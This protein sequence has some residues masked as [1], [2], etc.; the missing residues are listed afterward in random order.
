MI[1]RSFILAFALVSFGSTPLSANPTRAD[2]RHL[3]DSLPE[4]VPSIEDFHEFRS[5]LDLDDDWEDLEEEYGERKAR[6]SQLEG[7]PTSPLPIGKRFTIH[8]EMIEIINDQIT[9]LRFKR[10]IKF[11][12]QY[13]KWLV[14]LVKDKPK[15]FSKALQT[16]KLKGLE[17]ARK[18]GSEYRKLE[19]EYSQ[20][21]LIKFYILNNNENY[22]F[23]FK[24]FKRGYPKS[25][26]LSEINHIVGE[27]HLANKK[28]DQASQYFKEAF[29][30]KKSTIRPYSA[31]MLAWSQYLLA[32]TQKKVAAREKSY[33]K[34]DA[35]FRLALKLGEDWDEYKSVFPLVKEASKD[36]AWFWGE[37]GVSPKRVKKFFDELDQNWANEDYYYYQ[38]ISLAKKKDRD[39]VNQAFEELFS[40]SPES[41]NRPRYILKA[42]EICVEQG[43]RKELPQYFKTFKKLLEKESPWLDE[44]EDNEQY[45]ALIRKQIPYYL[46]TTAIEYHQNLVA[47]IEKSQKTRSKKKREAALTQ[48]NA[49]MTTTGE[50][51]KLFYQWYP[52]DKHFDEIS[53]NYGNILF[54][55]G[56][57]KEARTV[58]QKVATLETSSFR[59]SAAYNAVMAS[60]NMLQQAKPLKL[61]EPGKAKKPVPLPQTQKDLIHSIDYFVKVFPKAKEA[62]SS[63]YT[64]AQIY[65]DFGHYPE[66]FKRFNII[67]LKAPKSAEGDNAMRNIL[68][69]YWDR[70]EWKEVIKVTNQFLV[71][72][73]VIQ[74]GHEKFLEETLSYAKSQAA[75]SKK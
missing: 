22:S 51:Y 67:V 39:G 2:L 5:Q 4:A 31:Y 56:Q 58:F 9:Y 27:F 34:A 43:Y 10:N 6:L 8:K 41:K 33:K 48:A 63:A 37:R 45:V 46:R 50:L 42:I 44:W 71:E 54:E 55:K 14:E 18:M 75:M 73:A 32:G 65:Y 20:F 19:P 66:S 40:L 52:K 36:L 13:E 30:N 17:V 7:I 74:A 23:Y 29:S 11:K 72:P 70:G 68:S 28:Y 26:Y 47:L 57:L 3:A 24:K 21:Q 49:L 15:P 59:Q 25:E 60:Y 35:A 53:F 61:P 69:Y 12:E 62:V 38:A 1:F 16:Y 64:A